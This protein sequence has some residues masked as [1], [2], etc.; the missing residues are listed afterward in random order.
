MLAAVSMFLPSPTSPA[1]TAN[2]A[3]KPILAALLNGQTALPCYESDITNTAHFTSDTFRACFALSGMP[4][5]L[6]A[7]YWSDSSNDQ[8]QI[9]MGLVGDTPVPF[10][11]GQVD[12][13]EIDQVKQIL[14][15]T[16]RD[17]SAV[18]IDTKTTEKYQN[19]TSSDI[20]GMLADAHGMQKNIAATT[21]KVGTYYVE[22]QVA[23]TR[24]ESEWDLLIYLAQHEGF[25]LWVSGNTLNFQPSVDLSTAVP[26]VLIYSDAGAGGAGK[27]SSFTGLKMNRSQTLAKDVIVKVRTWNQINAKVYNVTAKRTQASKGQR[28]GGVAQ[29]YSFTVPNLDEEGALNYAQQKAE[30]ISRHERVIN[31]DLAGDN[32]LS[33][34]TPVQLVGT[35]TS[36][37]QKYYPDSITRR[38]SFEKYTMSLRA[39]NHS[40]ESTVLA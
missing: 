32:S 10:I 4:Q 7:S 23:L 8:I 20:A 1:A 16:G 25:D 38:I 27:F 15:L 18:F 34:R 33:I 9:S 28:S 26:Y 13:A 12:N 2:K 30:E 5:G 19:L 21:T 39:K 40:V 24:E 29:T 6:G 36:F 17:L 22:D 14:T 3:R 35:G 37:D 31:A 11:L